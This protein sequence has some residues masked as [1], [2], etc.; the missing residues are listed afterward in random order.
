MKKYYEIYNHLYDA[1]FNFGYFYK[2]VHKVTVGYVYDTEENVK[3]LVKQ[4]N[5]MRGFLTKYPDETSK[6][7][8]LSPNQK[9][10]EDYIDYREIKI[11]DF[12]REACNFDSEYCYK[13]HLYVSAALW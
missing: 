1:N 5:E 3:T 10:D 6:Y 8:D 11:R 7:H 9:P 4:L 2:R 12:D 13:N